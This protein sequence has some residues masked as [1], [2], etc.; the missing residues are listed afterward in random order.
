VIKL[1]GQEKKKKR[2]LTAKVRFS[3]KKR[4]IAKKIVFQEFGK[5]HKEGGCERRSAKKET[6]LQ[7]KGSHN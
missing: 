1:R 5:K 3:E 4:E 2:P 6:R 7:T